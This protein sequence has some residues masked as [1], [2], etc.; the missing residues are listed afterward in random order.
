M[1]K[2]LS[3]IASVLGC[4]HGAETEWWLGKLHENRDKLLPPEHMAA[5]RPTSLMYQKLLFICH[6]HM[7]VKL[8]EE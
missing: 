7:T 2:D 6:I 8:F 5:H 4:G 3:D 1:W